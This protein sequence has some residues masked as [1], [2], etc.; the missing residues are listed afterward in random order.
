[1]KEIE[2]TIGII[3]MLLIGSFFNLIVDSP[4]VKAVSNEYIKISFEIDCI[5]KLDEIDIGSNP[6]WYYKIRFYGSY[7]GWTPWYSSPWNTNGYFKDVP[8]YFYLP[9]PYDIQ[10]STISSY[11]LEILL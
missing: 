2:I 5:H 11:T 9:S 7:S 6:D 8:D 10:S 3:L 4:N 1:M